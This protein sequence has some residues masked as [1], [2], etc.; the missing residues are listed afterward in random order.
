MNRFYIIGSSGRL[1]CALVDEFFKEGIISID[2]NVYQEWSQSDGE[3]KV[4]KYFDSS[5]NEGAVIFI[6]SGLLDPKLSREDIFGVNF[7]LPKNIIEGVKRLRIKVVTFGSV[8]EN[9]M[10][11]KNY[12]FESKSRLSEYVSNIASN[13]RVIQHIQIHT[14]Y[15]GGPPAPFMFLGQILSALQTNEFFEMTQ[16]K[17]L[18]EYHHVLDEVK[19]IR[20]LLDVNSYG[21]VN[22]SHGNPLT[23]ANIAYSIFDSFGKR[24]LL[25]IGALPEP[26]E[27]N[28][29][30]TFKLPEFILQNDFRDSLPAI[31][32]YMHQSN[33]LHNQRG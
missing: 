5:Q 14:L 29:N 17:Q 15:G 23:L 4:F 22:I 16:G 31:V 3:D 18:R 24:D 12:Y 8:M 32:E 27:E 11:S 20:K 1:G 9:L 2:R 10:P 25:R 28:F 26:V 13:D 30:Q 7:L 33:V 6:A 19:A 21:T